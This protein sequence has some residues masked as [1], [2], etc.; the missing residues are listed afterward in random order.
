MLIATT[1]AIVTRTAGTGDPYE[2][3]AVTTVTT[4]PAHISDPS[5]ADASVGGHKEVI[6]AVAY[7][8]AG[9]SVERGDTL[10]DAT[11]GAAYAVS[12][13]TPRNGLGLSHVQ[14]GLT[15]VEG[16]SNGG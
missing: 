8:P 9:T 5:G 11:T 2:A 7:L 12:W 6:D 4:V 10:T 16:A 15:F 13:C 14:A 1:T 3:A